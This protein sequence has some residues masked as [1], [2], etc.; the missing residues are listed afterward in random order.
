MKDIFRICAVL[1]CACMMVLSL[2]VGCSN[3]A[4]DE[5][6]KHEKKPATVRRSAKKA[7]KTA[8]NKGAAVPE[9]QDRYDAY[10]RVK[11]NDLDGRVSEL[12]RSLKRST[13][14]SKSRLKRKLRDLKRK[15]SDIDLAYRKYQ[16][17]EGKGKAEARTDLDRS[18]SRFD[19]SSTVTT[20]EM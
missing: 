2:A 7:A 12:E 14:R 20:E 6:V 18:I 10:L 4:E 13:G 17:S 16:V 11:R 8:A 9:G 19:E 5:E 3:Q 1:C 15:K